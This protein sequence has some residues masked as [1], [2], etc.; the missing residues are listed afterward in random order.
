LI[1]LSVGGSMI[2]PG[3]PNMKFLGE[4]AVV[5]ARAHRRNGLAVVTGGGAPA[6]EFANAIRGMGGTHFLADK[7]A[8][9]STRQN[10]LLLI[11]ALG[12]DAWTTVPSTFDEAVDFSRSGRIV[13]MGG[14]IPGITT[15]ADAALLAEALGAERIVNVSK[16][17]G[18]Y[19]SDPKK[20]V[21]AKK[22]GRLGFGKL[23][24]LASAGDRRV[25]G[26]NFVFDLVA[27]KIVARS[28]IETHFVGPDGRDIENAISGKRHSGSIVGGD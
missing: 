23:L 18:I 5:L 22:I 17:D 6:R 20:D 19:S 10:A 28:G 4:L 11:S 2:N 21:N 7:A 16:V 9:L 15:D 13:V 1:V 12:K 24:E 8:I 26:E 25:A 14:T 3:R 27:C